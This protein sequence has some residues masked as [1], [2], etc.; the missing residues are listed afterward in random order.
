MNN[1][2]RKGMLVLLAAVVLWQTHYHNG[3]RVEGFRLA[4]RNTRHPILAGRIWPTVSRSLCAENFGGWK[5]RM[6]I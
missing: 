3:L 5:M 1:K 4:I 6:M 2:A